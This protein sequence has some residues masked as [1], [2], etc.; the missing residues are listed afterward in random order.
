LSWRPKGDQQPK[1]RQRSTPETAVKASKLLEPPSPVQIVPLERGDHSLE[2]AT[3]G[4]A[5]DEDD[6][7]DESGD[8]SD[9]EAVLDR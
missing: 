3:D 2:Q 7:G 1:E 6:R 4:A 9:Q 8:T 5:Q